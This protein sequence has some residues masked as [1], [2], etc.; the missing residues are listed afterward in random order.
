VKRIRVVT[1]RTVLLTAVTA[2]T[3]AGCSVLSPATI[4]TPY[5]AADGV[6]LVLPGTSVA[7][8][9][10]LVVGTAKD[11]PATVI[12]T[13]VNDGDSPVEVSLQADPGATGQPT[14]TLI[15]VGAHSSVQLGP[16]QTNKMVIS[17]LAVAPGAF[18]S[19]SA[20]TQAGG[21][22]D[23][24]VPVLL[25]QGIYASLT[26]APVP[27]ETASVDPSATATPTP[28]KSTK[29]KQKSSST[30]TPTPTANAT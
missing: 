21:R 29:K 17:D 6:G 23:I 15:N 16:D 19:L 13:V 20:A 5:P 25:P 4:I 3:L 12:G 7:L 24:N 26:P 22:A 28:G 10:L 8:R 30:T 14:Q 11:A 2:V 1:G 27:S 9:D 18:T